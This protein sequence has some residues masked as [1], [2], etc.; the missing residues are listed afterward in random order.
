MKLPSEDKNP[1]HPVS[2][3]PKLRLEVHQR[4]IKVGDH[5]LHDLGASFWVGGLL[6][7][8][9]VLGAFGSQGFT[10]GIWEG[11]GFRV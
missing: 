11:L 2:S 10:V 6:G 7:A 5:L 4:R 8:G 1:T 9:G 3:L